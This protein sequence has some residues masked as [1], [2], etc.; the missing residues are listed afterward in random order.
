MS[1]GAILHE[2]TRATSAERAKLV[3]VESYAVALDL[4]RGDEY[5]GATSVIRF[6]GLR[7]GAAGHADLRADQVHAIILNGRRLDP[8]QVK[9][10][11]CDAN[12]HPRL[13]GPG[14]TWEDYLT[15]AVTEIR[16]FGASDIQ[17]MRRLRALLAHLHDAVSPENCRAVDHEMARLDGT[18]TAAFGD[19]VDL[20]RARA[21][22][23]QGIGGPD[24]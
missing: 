8:A 18:V 7:P 15:L 12:G 5:F 10:V 2:I 3:R 11:F 4:T 20:D 23:H 1:R 13:L 22:D 21:S 24:Q 17:V 16:E 14:R 19:S 6:S 9:F